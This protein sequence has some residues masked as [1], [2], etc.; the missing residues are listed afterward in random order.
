RQP[1][2]PGDIDRIA[3]AIVPDARIGAGLDQQVQ[4]L[5]PLQ[6]RRIEDRRLAMGAQVQPR[7]GGEQRAHQLAL[8]RNTAVQSAKLAS[9]PRRSRNFT[10]GTF[11]L[12]DAAYQ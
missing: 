10:S 9:P 7:L 6:P 12:R 4:G 8:S 3:T 2:R 11:S 5:Q 1:P